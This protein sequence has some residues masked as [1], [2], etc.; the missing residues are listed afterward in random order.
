MSQKVN[1]DYSFLEVF[2]PKE[3][4]KAIA[5]VVHGLNL[6]PTR[7]NSLVSLIRDEGIVVL[8]MALAGHRG[9]YQD[10]E[11]VSRTQWLQDY[12]EA[13][14]TIK[15][16][17]SRF[18]DLPL[19]FLGKSLGALTFVDFVTEQEKP[20]FERA[21]LLAPA[22]ELRWRSHILKPLSHIHPK[23]P[24]PSASRSEDR[25]YNRLPAQ[26]Y[27]ALYDVFDHVQFKLQKKPFDVPSLIYIHPKDEL[28]SYPRLL[29]SIGSKMYTNAKLVAIDQKSAIGLGFFHMIVDEET[30]G[31]GV[32]GDFCQD[33]KN[34]FNPAKPL[35]LR[36]N[37]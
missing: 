37:N 28:V 20:A 30:M 31:E 17:Q 12:Q 36:F 34:F 33:L 32:W 6:K 4:P 23:I 10:L 25:I 5:L 29:K 8:N 35:A 15:Q 11:Q 18:G 2:F 21:I 9:N 19:Y 22:L 7:M 24:I 26:C 13:M 16:L 14:D 1:L 3:Q 27:G